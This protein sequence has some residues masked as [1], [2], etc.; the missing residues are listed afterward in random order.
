[1]HQIFIWFESIISQNT[2]ITWMKIVNLRF[3][4]YIC[5]MLA[6]LLRV[7]KKTTIKA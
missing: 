4:I 5:I 7:N 2:S 6:V 3:F 1:M